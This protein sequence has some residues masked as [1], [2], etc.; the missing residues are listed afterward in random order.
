MS[1]STER[2]PNHAED[3]PEALAPDILEEADGAAQISR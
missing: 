1:L 2:S 3:V